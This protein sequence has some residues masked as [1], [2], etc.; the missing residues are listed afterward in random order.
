MCWL[1]FYLKSSLKLLIKNEVTYKTNWLFLFYDSF[2]LFILI[3]KN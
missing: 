1:I 3:K 2:L